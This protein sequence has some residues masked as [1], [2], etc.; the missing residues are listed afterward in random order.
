PYVTPLTK[1]FLS[2]SKKNF[3]AGRIRESLVVVMSSGVACQ[4]NSSR[5]GWRHLS[6]F[7]GIQSRDS[8]TALGMTKKEGGVKNK[9]T[10]VSSDISDHAC[11]KKLSATSRDNQPLLQTRQRFA[12]YRACPLEIFHGMR[13]GYEP[14]F[15]LRRREVD[16]A[17]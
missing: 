4:A 10:P 9:L 15:K 17:L 2:P 11:C 5:E 6:V 3:A 1:N 14:R 13:R 7:E 16:A 8:S 12:N